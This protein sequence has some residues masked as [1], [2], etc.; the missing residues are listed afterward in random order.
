MVENPATSISTFAGVTTTHK[1]APKDTLGGLAGHYH[2]S[3]KDLLAANPSVNP[4]KLKI[5]ET[6]MIPAPTTAA[7]AAGNTVTPS[8]P[9]ATGDTTSYKVKA[10]DTLIKIASAHGTSVKAIQSVNGLKTTTIQVGKTLK[11]PSKSSAP[12]PAS[13]AGASA[14]IVPTISPTA[15]LTSVPATSAR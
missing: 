13:E 10:G 1:I 5:G 4:T 7:A 11:I 6:L 15:S 3:L 9:P 14:A 8:A 2:V 12:S